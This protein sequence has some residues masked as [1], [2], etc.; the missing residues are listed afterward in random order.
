MGRILLGSAKFRGANFRRGKI[1][2][3]RNFR[4]KIIKN[5]APF[6]QFVRNRA[7]SCFIDCT[8]HSLVQYTARVPG[9]LDCDFS[10]ATAPL[11]VWLAPQRFR[12]LYPGLSG[13]LTPALPAPLSQL[14]RRPYPSPSG[15]PTHFEG[16]TVTPLSPPVPTP[17]S[18]PN[19]R[20]FGG[21]ILYCTH[22]PTDP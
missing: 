20:I 18:R 15:A 3:K 6:G 17:L 14:F 11:S 2:Y 4:P 7:L 5:F 22:T 9:A 10:G 21:R 13:A 16:G 19:S 1:F 8:V 12:R